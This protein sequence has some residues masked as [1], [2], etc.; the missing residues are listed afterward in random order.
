[1]KRAV[2]ERDGGRCTFT[3]PDGHRC[4]SRRQL[5]LDHVHADWLGGPPAIDNLR[6][7]CRVHNALHAEETFGQGHM[8]RFRRKDRPAPR[9]GDLLSLAIA[10]PR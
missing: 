6:L 3:S 10:H 4:E 1:V 8:A 2:W 9:A 5:E 7:R